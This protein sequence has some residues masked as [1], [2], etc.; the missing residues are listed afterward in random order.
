MRAWRERG[1]VSG[2][3]RRLDRYVNCQNL[4]ILAHENHMCA[5]KLTLYVLLIN[6]SP[7]DETWHHDMGML[8]LS[9]EV[10]YS[11]LTGK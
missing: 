10:I 7:F 2:Q 1:I 5:G 3:N 6:Q 9:R 8:F 4:T 11:E